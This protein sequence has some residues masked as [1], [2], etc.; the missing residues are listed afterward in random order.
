MDPLL[1][2]QVAM[3]VVIDQQRAVA[4]EAD[5]KHWQAAS[6]C[7]AGARNLDIA[8]SMLISGQQNTRI[9]ARRDAF[10][11]AAELVRKAIIAEPVAVTEAEE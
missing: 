5:H 4:P 1:Q 2:Q 6:D 7:I 11:F 9:P 3:L 8:L 10:A